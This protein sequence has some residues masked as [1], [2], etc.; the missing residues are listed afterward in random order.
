VQVE[1]VEVLIEPD[2]TENCLILSSQEEPE[3][4]LVVD[5]GAEPEKIL[6]AVGERTIE[7]IVLTHRHHDHLG[8]LS[9]LV[10]DREPVIYAHTLETEAILDPHQELY[11]FEDQ[12][13]KPVSAIVSLDEGDTIHVG[14]ENLEIIHTPGHT[15]GS[16]CLYNERDAILIAGD[17]LFYEAAGRTDLPTGS[18]QQ[19]RE[20]L[21][22]L[23]QLPNATKVYPGHDQATDIGHEKSYGRL[24]TFL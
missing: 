4:V 15:I 2:F 23:A 11:P 13:L 18:S 17:T 20:S 3:T 22:K 1:V 9:R 8:A 16:M 24:G 7:A 14:P 19:L 12:P 5:P 6:R 10:Q 21:K